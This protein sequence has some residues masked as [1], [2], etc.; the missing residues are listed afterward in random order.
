[1]MAKS[2]LDVNSLFFALCTQTFQSLRLVG[3][4][5]KIILMD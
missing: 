2:E 4:R 5:V 1:M 3:T